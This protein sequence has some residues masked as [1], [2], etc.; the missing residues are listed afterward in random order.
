MIGRGAMGN[1]WIFN[2]IKNA[3]DRKEYSM[4]TYEEKIELALRQLDSMIFELGERTGLAQAKKHMAWYVSGIKG[5]AAA[6]DK[7][8]TAETAGQV[9]EVFA[10]LLKIQD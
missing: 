4:P 9:E 10:E 1:P 3:M 5:S 2:E 6:R 8:M 7:I